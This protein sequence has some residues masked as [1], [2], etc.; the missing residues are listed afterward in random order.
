MDAVGSYG[1]NADE[2]ATLEARA[3]ESFAAWEKKPVAAP[4]HRLAPAAAAF[5]KASPNLAALLTE[6][7]RQPAPADAT[8]GKALLG[9][10]LG[11]LKVGP[12]TELRLAFEVTRDFTGALTGTMVSMDESPAKIPLASIAEKDGA[13]H[14]DV[15]MIGGSFDGK[16]NADSSEVA[17]EWKQ[18]GQTFPLVLKPAASAPSA[19][20]SK[21]P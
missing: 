11:S 4:E 3:R 8:Q 15:P 5:P 10:W 7:D 1:L 20:G 14:F 9:H 2:A 17:G 21:R 12:A 18:S 6:L 13:A 16:L 19:P